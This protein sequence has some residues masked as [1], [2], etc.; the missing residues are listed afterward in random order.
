MEVVL[1]AMSK[2]NKSSARPSGEGL[3][4]VVQIKDECDLEHP[5][6]VFDFEP[7]AY[8]YCYI[9]TWNRYYFKGTQQYFHGR[10]NVKFDEDYLATW[11]TDIRN[12]RAFV[13]YDINSY[14][15]VDKRIPTIAHPTIQTNNVLFRSDIAHIP[16]REGT[17]VIVSTGGDGVEVHTFGNSNKLAG[18]LT[19]L[20]HW[21]DTLNATV[22]NPADAIS[23]FFKQM[24]GTSDVPSNIRSVIFLPFIIGG[25]EDHRISLGLY[26]TG[27]DA[28]RW[29]YD[30]ILVEQTTSVDIP[31]QTNDW[32]RNS[33]YTDLYLYIPFVGLINYPTSE[34]LNETTITIKSVL[35]ITTG[36]M[37]ILVSAGL[38]ILGTYG[39]N[40]AS[41]IPIGS[42][43]ISIPQL[44]TG[45]VKGALAVGGAVASAGA[46]LPVTMGAIVAGSESVLGGLE[47]IS[48]TMGG[49]GGGTGARLGYD[50]LCITAYHDTL[51][52]PSSVVDIIGAPSMFVKSLANASGFIQTAGFQLGGIATAPE[53][54]AVNAL[55]DSGVY[56]E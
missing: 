2:R 16:T 47:P 3:V 26:D 35:N 40:V 32:R 45:I 22:Q 9:P 50:I 18:L 33:P 23:V 20:D 28:Y 30:A 41:Q 27:I 37:S 53:K 48:S 5:E 17:Y 46:S 7:T 34:I 21:L 55:M 49:L 25:T 1:Y 42:A 15:I 4:L 43:G 14:D 6:F 39:A 31:W 8:N 51:V 24:I 52:E 56:L 29:D 19:D 12:S 10:W 54:D 36:E 13:M 44:T 11:L 38:V